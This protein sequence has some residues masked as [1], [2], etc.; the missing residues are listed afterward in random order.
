MN[1][2]LIASA[3]SLATMLIAC[4]RH[5]FGWGA[6]FAILGLLLLP[7]AFNSEARRG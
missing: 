2:S 5:D 6:T 7:S 1:L 4:V 3:L